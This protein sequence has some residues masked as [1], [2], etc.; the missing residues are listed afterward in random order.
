MDPNLDRVVRFRPLKCR[1]WSLLALGTVV[2]HRS[3]RYDTKR[4]QS[5][6]ESSKPIRHGVMLLKR[7]ERTRDPRAGTIRSVTLTAAAVTVR[8]NPIGDDATV[9]SGPETIA[10]WRLIS[11][12]ALRATC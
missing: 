2:S 4:D 10:A 11:S 3:E 12:L 6:H 9:F 7:K 5:A 1:R 8:R